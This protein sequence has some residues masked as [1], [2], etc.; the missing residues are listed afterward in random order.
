MVKVNGQRVELDDISH[1][2]EIALD[3]KASVCVENVGGT[4]KSRLV[5]FIHFHTTPDEKADQQAPLILPADPQWIAEISR[6]KGVLASHLPKYMIPSAYVP[7]SSKPMTFYGKLDRGLL[8]RAYRELSQD[9]KQVL[10][11]HHQSTRKPETNSEKTLARLWGEV[12]EIPAD[13]LDAHDGFFHIGGDSVSAIKLVAAAREELL[14][15]SVVDIF[16]CPRL[17]DMALAMASLHNEANGHN[18]TKPFSLIPNSTPG[19]VHGLKREAA[20]QCSVKLNDIEDIYPCSPLQEELIALSMRLGPASYR[21]I[22]AFRIQDDG[23]NMEA[24]RS[25]WQEVV[26]SQPV[27]RTRI[28]STRRAG[29]VQAVVKSPLV[30]EEMHIKLDDCLEQLRTAPLGYGRPLLRLAIVRDG[31]HTFFVWSAHHAIYDGW[32]IGLTMG[33][34][35]RAYN[36]FSLQSKPTFP[37]WP[38]SFN[39]YIKYVLSIDDENQRS[40]WASRFQDANTSALGFPAVSRKQ[41]SSSYALTS[42]TLT[43]KIKDISEAQSETATSILYAAWAL[44]ISIFTGTQRV[45]MAIPQ[46]GRSVSVANIASINGPTVGTVPISIEI[47]PKNTSARELASAIQ[48]QILETIPYSHYGLRNIRKVSGASRNAVNSIA[49]IFVVHPD[50]G[51][52]D[53]RFDG[54]APVSSMELSR[55]VFPLIVQCRIDTA[56]HTAVEA[57]YDNAAMSLPMVELVLEQFNRIVQQIGDRPQVNIASLSIHHPESAQ[58][59]VRWNM[60]QFDAG[61]SE[62]K[63]HFPSTNNDK[64]LSYGAY[65]A[66]IDELEMHRDASWLE[67]P[68]G[69][70][71]AKTCLLPRLKKERDDSAEEYRLSRL[72]CKDDTRTEAILPSAARVGVPPALFYQ[73]AW[74]IVLSLYTEHD[75]KDICFGLLTNESQLPT[76]DTV[77]TRLSRVKFP[78]DTKLS[79]VMRTMKDGAMSGTSQQITMEHGSQPL[80]NT[81][82]YLREEKSGDCPSHAE[83]QTKSSWGTSV[84]LGLSVSATDSS[85]RIS[86][87]YRPDW[88]EEE[89]ARIIIE[90]F[91]RAL[92]C[93]A[94]D[95]QRTLSQLDLLGEQNLE[96][97]RR[98]NGPDPVPTSHRCIFDRIDAHA[99]S[100]PTTEAIAS[101]DRSWTYAQLSETS[102][103]LGN[104]L[105]QVFGIGPGTVVPICFEKSSWAIVAMLSIMKAGA[106]FAPLDTRNPRGRLE[107]LI[108]QVHGKLVL[109]SSVTQDL[110][111]GTDY[112]KRFLPVDEE[113][114]CTLPPAAGS[115]HYV[116]TPQ[117]LS[118]II[119]TS[120]TTGTSKAIAMEHTA[121]AT[122]ADQVGPSLGLGPSSRMLQFASYSFDVSVG[123]IFSTLQAGGCVCVPSEEDR[124]NDLAGS[125]CRLRATH[126]MTTATVVSTLQPRDVPTLQR[127]YCGGERLSQDKVDQ[128]ADAVRL[129]VCKCK[130]MSWIRS[131]AVRSLI[132]SWI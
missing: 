4:G 99:N 80:F 17:L 60:S 41:S 94:D 90:V 70:F 106:A 59:I 125:I 2:L 95:P 30:W 20:A 104:H 11:L 131:F 51:V 28:I 35:N 109:G 132:I 101:W 115:E 32:S 33:A 113:Y 29:I 13:S 67:T 83:D 102:T 48:T 19:T 122:F 82:L 72:S 97:I 27:L 3:N 107:E 8:R 121:M 25:A 39:E 85:V 45:T 98:L 84:V 75:P 91:S 58:S 77:K 14:H 79:D 116:V 117:D 114:I 26:E 62:T 53:A 9:K 130:P 68:R 16:K 69:P 54:M 34:V 31:K 10:S 49:N 81:C 22:Q 103:R 6:A 88:I 24:Y 96:R 73:V 65:M 110:F 128:W 89:Q 37:S 63:V 105:R 40:F 118:W 119:F 71:T 12:L 15:L 93:L 112:V 18:E 100:H 44:T 52:F 108:K 5:A 42:T 127:I 43:R 46:T 78:E 50:D 64:Q 7:I 111:N 120:G 36:A 47:E 1:H 61:K 87:K 126:L 92:Q 57:R 21:G 66:E 38:G 76:T 56:G 74:A 55:D 123:E 86:L 23:F 124:M 129:V